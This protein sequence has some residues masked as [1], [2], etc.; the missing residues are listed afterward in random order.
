MRWCPAPTRNRKPAIK[1][2]RKSDTRN[3]PCRGIKSRHR[4]ASF[5][6]TERGFFPLY[7]TG[8]TGKAFNYADSPEKIPWL[9]QLFW[10]ARKFHQPLFAI[11]ALSSP[12]PH[13]LGLLWQDFAAPLHPDNHLPLD[14]YF[15]GVEVVTM[16]SSWQDDRGKFV[17]LKAGDNQAGHAHLDLGTFVLDAQGQRWAMD[18]GPGDYNLPDY[19]GPERWNYY[20]TLAEGHNTLVINPGRDPDQDPKASARISRY[21]SSPQLAWAIADLTPAY[22][23][24]V[25]K[26]WRGLALVNRRQVLIQDEIETLQPAEIWWS[27][28]TPAAVRLTADKKGAILTQNSRRWQASIIQPERAT[29][30]LGK[31]RPLPLSPHPLRQGDNAEVQKLSINLKRAQEMRLVVWLTPLP[32]GESAP[33]PPPEITTLA[34]W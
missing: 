26:V 13:P 17:A 30:E 16:R 3:N 8:P 14:K 18:L 10:L 7:L 2:P 33:P 34:D 28:H 4:P 29:F 19:F 27:P 12:R 6:E 9:A 15:R 1:G 31:A 23:H 22:A 21:H 20:R 11:P 32:D 24:Q 5:G 25:R